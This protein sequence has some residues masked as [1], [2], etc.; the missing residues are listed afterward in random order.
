MVYLLETGSHSLLVSTT[1]SPNTNPQSAHTYRQSFSDAF[2]RICAIQFTYKVA[3]G[4]LFHD[5]W[6]ID[7]AMFTHQTYIKVL[8]KFRLTEDGHQDVKF[9]FPDN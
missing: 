6:G 3:V 7:L 4:S 2:K 9:D 8:T 1:R 5:V